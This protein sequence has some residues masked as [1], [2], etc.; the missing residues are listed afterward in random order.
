MTDLKATLRRLKKNLRILRER[1]AKYGRDKPIELVNQI[2]DHEKAITLIEQCLVGEISEAELS[3]ACKGLLVDIPQRS[4]EA[5]VS[6]EGNQGRVDI[7][8]LIAG[9]VHGDVK[10]IHIQ[11]ADFINVG[12][13]LTQQLYPDLKD[14]IPTLYRRVKAPL[15]KLWSPTFR[16]PSDLLNA[17]RSNQVKP[18]SWVTL[19]CKP[20]M[21]GPFL[22]NHFLT[23]FIGDHPG[24]RLGPPLVTD[25]PVMQLVSQTTSHLKP[26]GLY[27]PISDNLYQICLYPSDATVCG[28]IGLIPGVNDVVKYI[29]AISNGNNLTFCG[30]SCNVKGIIR[31]V[32]PKLLTDAGVPIEK[33]E[34]L[35]QSGDIWFFDLSEAET[36]I[37]PYEGTIATEMWGGLYASGHIEILD[38]KLKIPPLVEGM[39]KLFRKANFEP[40]IIPN[41]GRRKEISVYSQGIRAVI[42]T[43]IPRFSIH[44]DAEI[45]TAYKSYKQ[46][47]DT[48]CQGYLKVIT[49][50]AKDCNVNVA[51]PNDLDFSYTNSAKSYSVLKSLGSENI[52]DPIGIAIRD[53][54][55]KR[56]K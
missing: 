15:D 52:A 45:G 36:E 50:V 12:N 10:N 49:E 55:R 35:R 44:M 54:H 5:A 16:S 11:R 38:G 7:E 20:S 30:M 47:F 24:M 25:N 29:P 53:W 14:W 27:P 56:G 34:E 17:L 22:R 13:F 8:N 37:E 4:N 39:A 26:V 21:F 41:R 3:E 42:D 48:V 40:H 9:D 2:D 32:D 46:K 18:D 19:K 33:Y 51:N 1:E 6:I 31:Q 28:M 23:P 43:Q